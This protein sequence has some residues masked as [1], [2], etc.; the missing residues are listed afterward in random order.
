M[1]T[2]RFRETFQY[3]GEEDA[4]DATPQAI[5]EEGEL[6]FTMISVIC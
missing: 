6:E 2:T 4:D 3:D 1:A 5:D